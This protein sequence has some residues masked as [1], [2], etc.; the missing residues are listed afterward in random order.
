MQSRQGMLELLVNNEGSVIRYALDYHGGERYPR[1][2]RDKGKPDLLGQIIA[3]H[4]NRR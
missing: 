1:L 2:E 4:A 3:P